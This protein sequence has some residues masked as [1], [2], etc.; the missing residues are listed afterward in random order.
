[1]PEADL[2]FGC[3]HYFEPQAAA[4]ADLFPCPCCGYLVFSEPPGCYEICRVCFWEDDFVQ[5]AFP[6]CPSG[7]NRCSLIQ[8]QLNFSRFGACQER[9]LSSVTPYGAARDPGWRPID[10]ERDRYLRWTSEE[11]GRLW[12]TVKDTSPCL[13]Y[14]R[15]DYWFNQHGQTT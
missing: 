13:Y 9:Y 8:A 6:E 4:M 7:A 2:E 3:S 10:S 14:W 11:D 12:N 15:T 5:L 1:M